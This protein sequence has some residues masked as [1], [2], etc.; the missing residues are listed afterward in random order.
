MTTPEEKLVEKY[1]DK[2]PEQMEK[3]QDALENEV[4][5]QSKALDQNI[6]NFSS[7][8]DEMKAPDGTLLAIVKR[9]T[10][11]Q[12]KRF[13]PPQLAKYREK[14]ESIPIEVATEY[15]TDIYNLMAELITRPEHTADEWQKL[16]GDDFVAVFQA[17]LFKIRQKMAETVQSFL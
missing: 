10:A 4:V 12:F 7:K 9:P 11:K 5:L 8:T 14:P 13:V 16:V 6:S 3:E 2:T 15:E 1:G 17:H